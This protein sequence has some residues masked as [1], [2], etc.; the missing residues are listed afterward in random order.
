MACIESKKNKEQL[1][2][3][4]DKIVEFE[5]RTYDDF[6]EDV[7]DLRKI[8]KKYN[9]GELRFGKTAMLEAMTEACYAT[10]DLC[11]QNARLKQTEIFNTFTNLLDEDSIQNV[12]NL[13]K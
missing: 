2:I 5:N 4:V 13:I 8:L 6:N 10:V 3:L 12:K 7:I 11:L 1:K 9:W